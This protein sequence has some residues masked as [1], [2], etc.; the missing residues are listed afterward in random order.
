[1]YNS[2]NYAY[3]L[4]EQAGIHAPAHLHG[5]NAPGWGYDISGITSQ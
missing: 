1:M 5:V 4:L 2:N 3:T